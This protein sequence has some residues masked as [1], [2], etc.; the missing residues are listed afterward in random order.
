LWGKEKVQEQLTVSRYERTLSNRDNLVFYT[1]VIF[2]MQKGNMGG[3]Y[4]VTPPIQGKQE[5]EQKGF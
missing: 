2:Y 3:V 1:I 5:Q 4:N